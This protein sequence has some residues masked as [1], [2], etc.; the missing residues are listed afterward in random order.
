MG[1]AEDANDMSAVYSEDEIEDVRL[2]A[3]TN[4]IRI[5]LKKTR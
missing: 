5:W 4:F 3:V 2:V 1:H